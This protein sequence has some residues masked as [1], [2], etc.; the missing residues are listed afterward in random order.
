M[1]VEFR[2][3]AIVKFTT[4]TVP[5][6]IVLVFEPETRHATIPVPGTHATDLA[7]EVDA[8]PR[9]TE[10]EVTLLGGYTKVH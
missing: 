4:A 1:E 9:A 7:E 6:A 2:P 5:F 8:D 10:I 3:V